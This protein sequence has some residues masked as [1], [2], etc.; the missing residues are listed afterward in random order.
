M[1]T[2]NWFK[3]FENILKLVQDDFKPGPTVLQVK[4]QN[5]SRLVPVN[6]WIPIFSM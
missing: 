5:C 3:M 2:Q 4:Y 1:L 6:T